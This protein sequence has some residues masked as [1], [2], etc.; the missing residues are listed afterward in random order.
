MVLDRCRSLQIC[1]R[2]RLHGHRPE[3]D[4]TPSFCNRSSVVSSPKPCSRSYVTLRF[5]R[6]RTW[7]AMRFE[8][9]IFGEKTRVHTR[10][11]GRLP[12]HALYADKR[13]VIVPAV[14]VTDLMFCGGRGTVMLPTLRVSRAYNLMSLF[15][16]LSGK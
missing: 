15:V 13:L 10:F 11:A 16:R 12:R 3:I 7:S 6:R 9:C 4:L 8:F 1:K 2:R 14:V 5:T